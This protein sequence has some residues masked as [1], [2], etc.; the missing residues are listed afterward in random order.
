MF[1][2]ASSDD[3]VA[4]LKVEVDLGLEVSEAGNDL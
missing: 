3:C 4:V 1:K 2:A